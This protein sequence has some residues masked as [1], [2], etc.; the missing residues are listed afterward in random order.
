MSNPN[1]IDNIRSR[2]EKRN[3]L[4]GKYSALLPS[5]YMAESE[6]EKKIIQL[7]TSNG[8]FNLKDKRILEIGGGSGQNILLLLRL[9]F[10]PENIYFN[11]LLESRFSDALGRL[12]SGIHSFP[13]N[14]LEMN[15]ERDYFDVI[16]QST[17]FTSILDENMKSALAGKMWQWLKPG[18]GILWYDFIYNNPNNTDVEGIR[19]KKIRTYFPESKIQIKRLTLAPPVCRIVTKIHPS[20]YNVFNFWPFLRTHVL[21]WITK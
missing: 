14:A 13:G 7:L 8:F 17:V 5:V 4:G 10:L 19:I 12:P 11:E 20:L 15:F 9:G 2:Y 1:E 3:N 16:L 18:G 6:K 21:C